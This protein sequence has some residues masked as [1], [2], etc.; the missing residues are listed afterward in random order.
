[1][2]SL[3]LSLWLLAVVEFEPVADSLL[4]AAFP[5]L[6]RPTMRK[7]I[8]AKTIATAKHPIATE[9]PFPEEGT[10]VGVEPPA[11]PVE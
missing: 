3:S 10:K 2:T 5:E 7:M 8:A 4:E 6:V 9:R 1:M 11:L